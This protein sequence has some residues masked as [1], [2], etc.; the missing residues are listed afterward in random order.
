[1][2]QYLGVNWIGGLV[3][4]WINGLLDQWI[5]GSMDHWSDAIEQILINLIVQ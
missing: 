3:D 1:M 2:F 4:C 5:V